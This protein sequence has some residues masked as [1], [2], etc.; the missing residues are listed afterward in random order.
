MK[1]LAAPLARWR[2]PLGRRAP[3]AI[4]PALVVSFAIWTMYVHLITATHASFAALLDWLPLVAL[5]AVVATVGWSFLAETAKRTGPGSAGGTLAA[6]RLAALEIGENHSRAIPLVV[7]ALASL[8]VGLLLAGMPYPLFW[9]LALLAMGCA[10]LWN[11]RGTSHGV[12]GNTSGR[13]ASQ[14]HAAW[15]VFLVGVA[16]VGVTLVANRPDPDDALHLSIPAT[17]LRFPQQPVLLHDTLYRLPD[18][19]ILA[20]FYRLNSYDVLIG[21]LARI[22]GV[23]LHVIAYLVLPPLLAIF[24]VL[25]WVYLLRRIVPERWPSVLLILFLVVLA[26]GEVHRAY[27]N[28]AFVRL[29]QGKAILAACMVPVIAGSALSFARNGGL[30]HWLLLFAAQTAAVGVAATAL[31]VAPAAALLGLAGGW[32]ADVKSSRRFALGF[33]A[34]TYVFAAAWAMTSATQGGQGFV[35]SN[36]MP[37]V[38]QILDNTWGP[39]STGVLLAALLAAWA[40]VRDPARARYLSA[41]AFFFLL[42][43]LNPYTCRFVAD[44]FVGVYTY[45]RLTWALPLPFLI[46]VILDGVVGRALHIRPKALAMCIFALLTGFAVTFGWRFGTLRADN[47][48]T[49]GV[50]RLKVYPVEYRVARQVVEAVPETGVVLA[51]KLVAFWLPTFVVHPRLLGVRDLYLTRSFARPEAERRI[52]L[53]QYVAGEARS[54]DSAVLFADA[55]ERYQLTVVV[56]KHSASWR[57]E[58]ESVLES[59]AFQP[60]SSGPYDTWGRDASRASL[61]ANRVRRP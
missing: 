61:A 29:F 6:D 52:A 41:G 26:L 45:W 42:A 5:I 3:D 21:L 59:C 60:L 11:L 56:L 14:K 55:I 35:T 9:W 57:Q 28:F 19:P 25:T 7:V 31:F 18:A 46:A 32:S 20:P 49:L 27:G 43:V 50:P 58:M 44:H 24:C 1:S 40:F 48:V 36:P 51:P 17:L 30:R 2:A 16:A 37:T 8:W 15:I 47:G 10:W 33:L 53:M 12:L 54:D 22:T 13:P 4:V 23:D 34:S 38:P 39:W